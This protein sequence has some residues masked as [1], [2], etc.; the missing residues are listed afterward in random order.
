MRLIVLASP[1]CGLEPGNLDGADLEVVGDVNA[2][3]DSAKKSSYFICMKVTLKCR[4]LILSLSPCVGRPC[5]HVAVA[6]A[7]GRTQGGFGVETPL[8]LI[9][10]KNVITFAKE[11]NCFRMLLLVN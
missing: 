1:Q 11:S 5:L 8:S 7:Q 6:P 9:F 3:E 2:P 10:Y 4:L